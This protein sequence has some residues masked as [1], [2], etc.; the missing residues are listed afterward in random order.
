G[1][2]ADRKTLADLVVNDPPAFKALVDL[3]RAALAES[4]S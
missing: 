4:A 3:A 2:V 1:V